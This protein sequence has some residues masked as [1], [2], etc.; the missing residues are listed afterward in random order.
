[1]KSR[2]LY[3]YEVKT[4]FIS[5]WRFSCLT[6]VPSCV[7]T[8]RTMCLE[9]WANQVYFFLR[10][11]HSSISSPTSVFFRKFTIKWGKH[12]LHCSPVKCYIVLELIFITYILRYL[13][14]V[15]HSGDSWHLLH[16]HNFFFKHISNI[17]LICLKLGNKMYLHVNFSVKNDF[18][19][20]F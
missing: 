13:N 12:L 17:F 1:M 2:K 19:I 9:Q 18:S 20:K 3:T 8:T 16:S 4:D 15:R 5:A 10:V 7:T 6:L 14:K 11:P